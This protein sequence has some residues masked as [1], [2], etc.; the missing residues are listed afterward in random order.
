MLMK[1]KF[2]LLTFLLLF[3]RGCDFYSTS[4]WFFQE[5]G[6]EGERNPLTY[7][8]GVGWTGLIISNSIIILCII[9]LLYYFYFR[10]KRPR[11]FSQEPRNYQELA[12]LQ[13]FEQSGRFYQIF[14]RMP[15][16]R[17]VLYAHLG[18]VLTIVVIVGSFL[19]T[20][21]NISQ[22]YSFDFYNQFRQIVIRPLF[23]I[24]ALLFLTTILTYRN[25]LKSE[26]KKYL[27]IQ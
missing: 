15:K 9:G 16:N 7:F 2:I 25:L 3:S 23:V 14:F 19:A 20:F 1:M 17:N 4:L 27:D 12:S 11:H 6:M 24:Y 10:Y 8:F 13:Y 5:G 21:H 22:Y 18:F 26:Y